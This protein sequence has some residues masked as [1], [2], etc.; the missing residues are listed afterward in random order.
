MDNQLTETPEILQ[1]DAINGL[2]VATQAEILKAFLPYAQQFNELKEKA[3]EIQVTDVTQTD[4]IKAA[5][6]ARKAFKKIRTGADSVREDLKRE[7]LQYGRAVQDVYNKFKSQCE[8]IEAYLEQQEKFAELKA[9]EERNRIIAERMDIVKDF[10]HVTSD[11]IINLD[12]ESFEIF[13]EGLKDRKAK[14]EAA[15]IAEAEAEEKRLAI[16]QLN[17]ERRAILMEKDYWR[18]I[19]EEGKALNFGELRED[20]FKAYLEKGAYDLA[21]YNEKQAEI[22]AENER[23][24]KAAEE[25]ERE[26]H[27]RNEFRQDRNR[28]LQEIGYIHHC[29]TAD[30]TNEEFLEVLG[31]ATEMENLRLKAKAE[32]EQK[33]AEERAEAQRI[34]AEN[35]RMATELKQRQEAEA[36]AKRQEE[37]Q[38]ASQI[39][40]MKRIATAGDKEKLQHWMN[41]FVHGQ[42]PTMAQD[43]A[44]ETANEI[45][46]KFNAFKSW[47]DGQ[48][49]KL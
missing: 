3:K 10:P 40:E 23:L 28:Q 33:A 13:V 38:K 44:L 25:K 26:E 6:E 15:A 42:I 20:D 7:S 16:I 30:L 35:D 18:F 11:M 21:E 36:E 4:L 39:A 32:A 9:A 2:A 8:P 19:S 31:K 5:G 29:D 47:A 45:Q 37:L 24:K 17:Q 49:N 46:T 1:V 12:P 14:A 41:T 48:I 27:V 22:A 43:S 34:Q